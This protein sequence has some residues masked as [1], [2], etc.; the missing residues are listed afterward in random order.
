MS[1]TLRVISV[2]RGMKVIAANVRTMKVIES[3]EG[4]L[5]ASCGDDN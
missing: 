5:T 3:A 1:F 4:V 2:A